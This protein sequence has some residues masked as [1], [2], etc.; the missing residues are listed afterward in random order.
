MAFIALLPFV[1]PNS[2]LVGSREFT[3]RLEQTAHLRHYAS[4]EDSATVTRFSRMFMLPILTVG[5]TVFGI[6]WNGIL[7]VEGSIPFGSTP[8]EPLTYTLMQ[9]P[10]TMIGKTLLRK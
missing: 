7:E 5:N 10:R 8:D 3:T 1:A 6:T 4:F 2:T 9:K